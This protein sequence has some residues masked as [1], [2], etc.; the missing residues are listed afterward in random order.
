[1][2][3]QSRHQANPFPIVTPKLDGWEMTW[4]FG[5]R[6]SSRSAAA[7]SVGD[8]SP[9]MSDTAAPFVSKIPDIVESTADADDDEEEEEEN[10]APEVTGTCLQYIHCI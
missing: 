1:M 8:S 10:G 7:G 5:A 3:R 6:P 2:S 9:A 4:K